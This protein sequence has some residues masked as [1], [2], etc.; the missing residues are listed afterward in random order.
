MSY[1]NEAWV[2]DCGQGVVAAVGAAHML[3]VVEDAALCFRVPMAPTHCD[4]VLLWQKRVLPVVD[5]RPLIGV[6]LGSTATQCFCVLGWCTPDDVTEYGVIATTAVPR[7][8][9]VTDDKSMEPTV[10]RAASWRS[11]AVGFFSYHDTAVPILD[12][13]TLFGSRQAFEGHFLSDPLG[14]ITHRSA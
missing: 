1:G 5:M 8:I 9:V 10:E 11:F 2:L 13:A 7:R 6:A 12:P 3:H 4:R 14:N